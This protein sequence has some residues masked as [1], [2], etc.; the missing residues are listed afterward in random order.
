MG[1]LHP[2]DRPLGLDK[3]R[4]ALES[5]GMFIRPDPQAAGRYPALRRY[6]G[7]LLDKQRGASHGAGAVVN[8]VPIRRESAFTAKHV[9]RGEKD[10]V[11]EFN[12][13]DL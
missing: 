3:G 13:P 6:G 9:H 10:A 5:I 4:D 2:G 11:F 12:A 8:E 1:Q 7:R